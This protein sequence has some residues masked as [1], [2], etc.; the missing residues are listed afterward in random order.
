MTRLTLLHSTPTTPSGLGTDVRQQATVRSVKKMRSQAIWLPIMALSVGA[1]V[2]LPAQEVLAF[3]TLGGTLSLNQRDFRVFDNFSG[4]T[5]SN[6]SQADSAFPG[7]GG[8]PLAIWKASVEWGSVAH[9]DGSGDPT[10]SLLGDGGANFD[11]SFQGLATQVG[12]VNDNIHSQISGSNNGTLAYTETPTSDGWRIRYYEQWV[13][14]DGPGSIGFSE[15]DLQGV[16]CHEYGHALG[17]GHSTSSFATMA[18]STLP[19]NYTGRSI[20][21]DDRAGIQSLYGVI[22]STKPEITS[23]QITG[24]KITVFGTN[25]DPLGNQ[26]WFTRSTPGGLGDP[27]KVTNI[28]SNGTQLTAFIPSIA[29]PG[30]VLMRRNGTNHASLSNAWPTDLLPSSSACNSPLAFCN[31]A[32]NSVGSGASIGFNGGASITQNNLSLTVQGCP[33]DKPGIFYYGPSKASSPLGNGLRC[34]SGTTVRLPALTTDAFGSASL[35]LDLSAGTFASG[36]GQALVGSEANFQFWYRDPAAAGAGFNLSD[37][38]EV[39]YCL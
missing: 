25:F 28:P 30:D 2:F 33:A 8:A 4:A 10:Q 38:L 22:S 39:H 24:G 29:G 17:L 35:Q 32:A 6:N 37:A 31:G 19:G 14:A 12:G 9:G 11:A 27:V 13:W 1:I 23:V 26:L 3:S 36:S 7:Y 20:T 16:A 5:E 15:I 18:P 34:V 21:N